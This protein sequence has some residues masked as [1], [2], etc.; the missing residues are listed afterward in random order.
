LVAEV[1]PVT[2]L[3]EPVA[4]DAIEAHPQ[5]RAFALLRLPRPS[6]MPVSGPV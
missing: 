3:P 2:R 6:V 5:F 4:L 1:T